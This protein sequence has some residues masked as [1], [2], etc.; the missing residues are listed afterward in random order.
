[1]LI[2]GLFVEV[3]KK[4][5]STPFDERR[6]FFVTQSD[7]PVGFRRLREMCFYRTAMSD[8]ERV[9]Q[10]GMVRK[11]RTELVVFFMEFENQSV[12][13]D[14]GESLLEPFF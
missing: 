14:R 2:N 1:M 12:I 9:W 3:I 8:I 11:G 4:L 5:F 7:N 10:Y 6:F 13:F